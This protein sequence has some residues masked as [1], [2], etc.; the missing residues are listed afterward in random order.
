MSFP[1][2]NPSLLIRLRDQRDEQAWFDFVQLYRPSLVALAR[3]KGLQ[4]H[5]CEDLAQ[6]VLWAVAGAIGRFAA[7][8]GQPKFRTWL[9]T[10][11][12]RRALDALRNRCQRE[13]RGGTTVGHM[14]AEREASREDSRWLRLEVRRQAFQRAAHVL[15][16]EFTP[17]IWQCFWSVVVEGATPLDVAARLGKGV[18]AVYAAKARVARRLCDY[19]QATAPELSEGSDGKEVAEHDEPNTMGDAEPRDHV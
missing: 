17:V 13:V 14:L 1:E 16:D 19:L 6:S 15:R 5:D 3:R 4:A 9:S 8:P 12:H 10:I 2:T 7:G 18:G 11:A